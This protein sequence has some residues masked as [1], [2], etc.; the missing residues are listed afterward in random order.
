MSGR[1]TLPARKHGG[2]EFVLFLLILKVNR[3]NRKV[4]L[5]FALGLSLFAGVAR[6]QGV[7]TGSLRG[8]VKS[9]DSVA[10]PDAVVE[11]TSSALQGKR[12]VSSDA[13]GVYVLANLP[14]GP[15]TITISKSGLA[16]VT[17]NI[18]VPLGV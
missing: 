3:M 4:V 9:S 7:Q 2:S 8:I 18:A 17:R 10:L 16:T 12:A 6:G 1:G 15:Y 14:P 11:V 5:G 13:N